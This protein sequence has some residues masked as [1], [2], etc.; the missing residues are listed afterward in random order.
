MSP[1]KHQTE[2]A[3]YTE[4][5][6]D[7]IG[8]AL[9]VGR[10]GTM[11]RLLGPLF[12]RPA[13][14]FGRIA[15]LAD[16]EVES[17]G[18]SGGARRVLHDFSL[19]IS[20]RGTELI[21]LDGPLLIV[22]NHPGA[23]DSLA[24]LSCIPRKDTKV[25]LSDVAFTRAFAAARRYFIYVPPEAGRR[26]AA[27]R[28]SVDHLQSGG[29]VLIFAHGDVE[30]DPEVSSGAWDSIQGWSRSVEIMLRRVPQSRLQTAIVSGVLDRKLVR[31]PIVK[32]RRSP[33][34]RQKLAEVLQLSRQMV[35]AR[36]AR[37]HV[38]ITFAEPVRGTD[39]TAEEV[40]PAVIRIARGL[41]EVHLASWQIPSPP[42]PNRLRN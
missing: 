4:K 36:S 25:L 27:L 1:P 16:A 26:L 9:G 6:I 29:S 28:T 21:P 2:A 35:F 20:A 14:R 38:H 42:S 13:A 3:V 41:L 15:A 37:N 17:S 10:S 31:S 19:T 39:L 32:I 5:I 12:R 40:M 33:A 24:V 23:L 11:R 34:R 8:Y 7:E 22:S 30:P 18:I